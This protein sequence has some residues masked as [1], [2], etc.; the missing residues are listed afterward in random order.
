MRCKLM[1]NYNG[2][3]YGSHKLICFNDIGN[4]F[5]DITT[6]LHLN[7]NDFAN[8]FDTI[9]PRD[10]NYFVDEIQTAITIGRANGHFHLS[11]ALENEWLELVRNYNV[12]Y[13]NMIA[14]Y[15]AC[16]IIPA[17]FSLHN[18]SLLVNQRLMELNA[19][20]DDNDLV[21]Q[22]NRI[23]TV[24]AYTVA[25][26]MLQSYKDFRSREIDIEEFCARPA[27]FREYV[28]AFRHG[29][30]FAGCQ[31]AWYYASNHNINLHLWFQDPW[32]PNTLWRIVPSADFPNP[33][34]SIHLLIHQN[35]NQFKMLTQIGPEIVLNQ[36]PI[37]EVSATCIKDIYLW[38]LGPHN[39]RNIKARSSLND[40]LIELSELKVDEASA[41]YQFLLPYGY[42]SAY[43]KLS[44][45]FS[46]AATIV[47]IISALKSDA[48]ALVWIA[49]G[50][51]S[52][53]ALIR[54]VYICCNHRKLIALREDY[55]QS[56][57]RL[58]HE[59]NRQISDA[60]KFFF[61]IPLTA[62]FAAV[63]GLIVKGVAPEE[64]N[65]PII[66][67]ILATL[68][69]ESGGGIADDYQIAATAQIK[70]DETVDPDSA[71]DRW[72]INH[73]KNNRGIT[74]IA[75]DLER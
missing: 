54:T 31:T 68:I 69:A 57:I 48:D 49:L 23:I 25:D 12:A 7:R 9:D 20:I 11:N 73:F 65:A 13:Q 53:S 67:T 66:I 37:L 75:P 62:F 15:Q 46:L 38:R 45:P 29:R 44:F 1:L 28:N 16:C 24:N 42:V 18:Y 26:R 8:Y 32:L 58:L 40:F 41:N 60:R 63:A 71:K 70:P 39:Q 30:P 2:I 47:A 34:P 19:L 74:M 35:L 14:V 22:N 36:H 3:K 21:P 5:A 43:N 27:V 72:P 52:F 61:V 4:H 17:T 10:I 56:N 59:D 64:K 51:A 6:I 55:A 33:N 50:L